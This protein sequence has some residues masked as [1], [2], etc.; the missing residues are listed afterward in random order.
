L[1]QKNEL[2]LAG[3]RAKYCVRRK[4][5]GGE[6]VVLYEARA[7][8]KAGLKLS[9]TGQYPC[10]S[11]HAN[12]N[13]YSDQRYPDCANLQSYFKV[14]GLR[15]STLSEYRKETGKEE[16]RSEQGDDRRVKNE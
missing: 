12:H 13:S 4:Q 6:E 10:K 11:K 14:H 5:L 2:K 9:P 16:G 8:V 7:G 3:R 1:H 15:G